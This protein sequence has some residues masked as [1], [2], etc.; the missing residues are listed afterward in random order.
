MS[1]LPILNL[2]AVPPVTDALHQKAEQICAD[3]LARLGASKL[4]VVRLGLPFAAGTTLVAQITASVAF[5]RAELAGERCARAS[6]IAALLAHAGAVEL[7]LARR[8]LVHRVSLSVSLAGAGGFDPFIQA[9]VRYHCP[10]HALDKGGAKR[11]LLLLA[12]RAAA[13]GVTPVVFLAA[14]LPV[15]HGSTVLYRPELRSSFEARLD[16]FT[17][18]ALPVSFP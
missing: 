12:S 4:G 8:P 6:L 9:L 13:A 15:L 16:R 2:A 1:T 7:A 17:R 14:L 11:A 10:Y 5:V 18:R 3:G